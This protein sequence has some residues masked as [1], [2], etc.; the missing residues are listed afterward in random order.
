MDPSI[1][2][3]FNLQKIQSTEDTPTYVLLGVDTMKYLEDSCLIVFKLVPTYL[4]T[5]TP[6]VASYRDRSIQ[7]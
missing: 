3:Y 5:F 6:K 7:Q 1:V 2:T 4:C